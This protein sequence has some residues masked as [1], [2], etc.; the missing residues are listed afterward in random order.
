MGDLNRRDDSAAVQGPQAESVGLL[1]AKS[2]HG[3]KN[4]EGNDKVG[5]EHDVVLEVDAQAVGAEL[6][7]KNVKLSSRKYFV[8]LCAPSTG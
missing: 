3:L 2:G 8:S 5:S 1:N 7:S 4:S 6:L